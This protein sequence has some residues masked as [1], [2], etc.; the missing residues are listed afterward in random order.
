MSSEQERLDKAK[1]KLTNMNQRVQNAQ[2]LAKKRTAKPVEALEPPIPAKPELTTYIFELTESLVADGFPEDVIAKYVSQIETDSRLSD[3]DLDQRE[4]TLQAE[5]KKINR[6]I[7]RI[8]DPKPPAKQPNSPN[9][10]SPEP[11]AVP[12]YAVMHQARQNPQSP[13]KKV[14]PVTPKKPE[15]AK[16]E[17]GLPEEGAVK[18]TGAGAK[19][20]ADLVDNDD[21]PPF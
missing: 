7:T 4:L 13:P 15:K 9:D 19:F 3:L 1:E 8:T 20:L 21:D 11:S 2:N 16:K 6:A 17:S 10:A 5:L 18:T 12:G 14:P